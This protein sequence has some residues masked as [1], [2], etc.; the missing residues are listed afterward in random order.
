[1]NS[2]LQKL[3]FKIEF[4]KLYISLF[5]DNCIEDQNILE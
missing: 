5:N 3:G 1:M 4:V 2:N